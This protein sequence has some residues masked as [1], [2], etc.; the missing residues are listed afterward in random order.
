[1]E[2]GFRRHAEALDLPFHTRR[3]GS[4][5]G[6]FFYDP[7][8]GAV[9]GVRP[10]AALL[11]SLHFACLVEGLFVT[12]KA[13][14]ATSTVMTE[15]LAQEVVERFGRALRR[16]VAEWRRTLRPQRPARP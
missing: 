5:L 1:L 14:F 9:T 6:C 15:A 10:D 8:P 7:G 2:A 12:P 3:S 4:L 11:A 16:A 13:A